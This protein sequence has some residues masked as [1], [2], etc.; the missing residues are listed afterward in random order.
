MQTNND[1]LTTL[2]SMATIHMLLLL[3]FFLYDDNKGKKGDRS[4]RLENGDDKR[5]FSFPFLPPPVVT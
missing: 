4:S 5:D 1:N 3:F 2:D